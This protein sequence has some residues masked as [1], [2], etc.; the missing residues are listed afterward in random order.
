MSDGSA[1]EPTSTQVYL[2][3]RPRNMRLRLVPFSRMISARSAW[4]SSLMTSA[5]PS[6]QLMFFVS[7]KLRAAR[8]PKVPSGRPRYSPKRPCALSST[9]A[10]PC[11]FATAR[12]ASISQPTPA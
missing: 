2:S 12:I 6:P 4:R 5:P 7:W 8:L 3:T 10:S 11:R 9:T 1:L